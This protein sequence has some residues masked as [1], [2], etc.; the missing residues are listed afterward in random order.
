MVIWNDLFKGI[1]YFIDFRVRGKGE[2]EERKR[3][4]E[5]LICC[6]TYFCI[7]WL[8]LIHALTGDQT[9]NLGILVY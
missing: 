2:N 9:H 5:T 7:H 3:E 8:L 6:S 1:F 4:R